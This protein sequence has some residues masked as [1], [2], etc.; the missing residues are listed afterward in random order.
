MPDIAS[1]TDQQ[2]VE[3]WDKLEDETDLADAFAA[4]IEKRGLDI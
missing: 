4:E 2:L 3:A 1:M